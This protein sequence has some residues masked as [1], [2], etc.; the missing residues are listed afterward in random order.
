MCHL[1]KDNPATSQV[2]YAA[3]EILVEGYDNNKNYKADYC[4]Y[5]VQLHYLETKNN[6][7]SN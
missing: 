4:K 2:K 3:L 1:Q 6:V 7:V 5:R